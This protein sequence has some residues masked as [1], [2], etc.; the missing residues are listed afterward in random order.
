MTKKTGS[1]I[2]SP[3]SKTS[4]LKRWASSGWWRKNQ[5]L[6]KINKELDQFVYSIS[7]D[8]RAPLL[9]IQGLLGL[10]QFDT[11]DAGNQEFLNLIAESTKRL[12]HTILE[13]LN[14]S[15]NARMD[16]SLQPFNLKESIR[17]ILIDLSSFAVGG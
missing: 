6:T 16:I 10:I 11:W 9:S 2:S 17:D 1:S 15:R 4:P 12:D 5:E 13:I 3:S 14:Y 7:H 8:L